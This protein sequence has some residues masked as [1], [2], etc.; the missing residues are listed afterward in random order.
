MADN[1]DT[2]TA[3]DCKMPRYMKDACKKCRDRAWCDSHR[4]ISLDDLLKEN[5]W[6]PL[7]QNVEIEMPDVEGLPFVKT[8]TK[9][10]LQKIPD[11]I[12]I[13]T[14]NGRPAII[15]LKKW[16]SGF[17]EEFEEWEPLQYKEI[18]Q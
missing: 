14:V 17:E 9:T 1:W 3:K 2:E 10:N 7:P 4:Q 5:E 13:G 11:L 16:I 8:V 15:G 18:K 12:T 6:K